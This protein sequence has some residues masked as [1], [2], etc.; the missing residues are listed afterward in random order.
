[1][2]ELYRGSATWLQVKPSFKVMKSGMYEWE[3]ALLTEQL[4]LKGERHSIG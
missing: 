2:N 4:D 1:M 3:G